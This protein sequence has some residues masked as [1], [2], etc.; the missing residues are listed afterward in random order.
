MITATR[1]VGMRPVLIGLNFFLAAA[2]AAAGFR[3]EWQSPSPA[4]PWLQSVEAVGFDGSTVS[5]TPLPAGQGEY[6]HGLAV[7]LSAPAGQPGWVQVRLAGNR[8]FT[9]SEAML[10]AQPYIWAKDLGVFIS[11]DGWTATAAARAENA[12]RIAQSFSAPFASAA[13]RYRD[14]SGLSEHEPD[15]VHRLIWEF[16]NAKQTWPAEARTMDRIA[17]QPEVDPAYFFSRVPDLKYGRMYLGW[18]DHN[19]Q[20]TLRSHG[21]VT[22]SSQSVGGDPKIKDLRWHPRAGAY[23]FRYAVGGQP[24]PPY[25]ERG[26]P[27]VRQ[28]LDDGHSLVVTTTW[29]NDGVELAQTNFALPLEGDQVRTGLEPLLLWSRVTLTNPR[30]AARTAWFGIEFTDE[31][32]TTFMDRGPLRGVVDIAWRDGAFW[33]GGRLLAVA[34]P[35]L[36]FEVVPTHGARRRFQARVE[37]PAGGARQFDLA[38]FY[39]TDTAERVG[40]VRAAG[41]DASRR[42][43]LAYWDRLAA[44]GAA[45]RVPDEWLNNL[46]RTFLPRILLNAHLDPDGMVVLHTG[47]IQYPR[48][49]HHITAYGVAGDLARRGQFALS[50]RYFEPIFKWQGIP[51]PDSPAITDWSGFF[52]APPEQCAKVWLSYHGTVLW[53][54]SRYYRLSGDRAW[55]DE[56]MPALI[57]AMDWIAHTRRQTMRPNPDGTL[58]FHYGWFPAGRVSDS[59]VGTS[60]Y[61]DGSLW[62]GLDAMAR[63]LREI[64]HPRAAEFQAEADDYRFRLQDGMRR[65]S[66]ERPLVRLNDDTWVPYFPAFLDTKGDERDPKSKYSN[67]VDAAWAWGLF[68]TRLFGVGAPEA[69]WLTAL[70]EDAYTP[71]VPGLPDE[72]FCSGT[73]NEYLDQDRIANFL[74]TF[75]SQSTNTLDR[76]TMTTFEHYSW[77]QK[78]AYELT[79]WAAGYWTKNFTNLL[80]RTVDDQ[81]WLLQAAPRRWLRDGEQIE[82]SGLQTE[83]GPVSFTVRSR[84]AAGVIEARV[85]G[86]ARRAPEKLRLRLRAPDGAKLRAV[87][88]NGRP[89]SDFDPA[90]EW[91]VLPTG[92]GPVQ[93]EAR[94]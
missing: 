93:V 64:G 17:A 46:Y 91:I 27:E 57:K 78:R 5:V 13:E 80:C 30:P 89:W 60:V 94:Y 2:A 67:V 42:R 82:V 51:A 72:P 15:D 53:A 62:F 32:L 3:I 45:I 79:P 63:V 86:P 26:D 10:A 50:R 4:M 85:E 14:W 43:M 6:P 66:A 88:V 70:W 39:R 71:M 34:D 25:R 19:D 58:P 41:F 61:S 76:E 40:A 74:Y 68:D 56:K 7:E 55:L 1:L 33:V 37:L 24:L 29:Q 20:F 12:A 77:G 81:L 54:V 47:P 49:W 87:T 75:Y 73:M 31:D 8:G 48:V 65:T 84:L 69:R 44:G 83:F 38:H 28:R 59:I 52:G 16:I 21:Q 18:P 35:G 36:A 23:S 90:S 11:R 22:V 92:G 9:V